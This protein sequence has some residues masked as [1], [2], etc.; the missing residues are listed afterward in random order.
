VEVAVILD[1]CP[2]PIVLAPLA[3]GPATPELAAAVTN[4][5]GLGFLAAGYL[6]AAELAARRAATQQLTSGPV[7][8]NVFV[9]GAPRP[10]DAVQRYAQAIEA[11]A[12]TV[13]AS[14]GTQPTR[15]TTGRPKSATSSRIPHR[16]SRSR[17]A[18]GRLV[19]Q[20]R[21][22]GSEV[23][24]TVT[25]VP[26]AATAEELGADLLVV[27]GAEAGGHRG[28]LDDDPEQAVG[29]LALLQLLR[30]RVQIPLVAAGCPRR[31]SSG[32]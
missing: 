24:M 22:R 13:G 18:D 1:S 19:Q 11:D 12:H 3:G 27:Q 8:I 25:S 7:G 28:G 26:E 9:P 10:P 21:D 14:V 5:G 31:T 15:T 17:S 30:A 4:A 20:L 2:V 32:R 16:S 23:W 29:L 6:T